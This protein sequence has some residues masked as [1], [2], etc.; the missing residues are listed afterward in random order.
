M[1]PVSVALRV[2]FH[3]ALPMVN[4]PTA[5][6]IEGKPLNVNYFLNLLL[7]FLRVSLSWRGVLH[8]PPLTVEGGVGVVILSLIKEE[9]IMATYVKNKLYMV[10]LAELQPDPTQPRKFMDPLALEELTASVRQNGIIEPIIC[11]QDPKTSLVYV[12]AGE[13]RCAAA[14]QAG[15]THVPAVF[16]M[17]DNYA[18]IALVGNLLRQD[19]N[20]I[21]EA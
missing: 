20:P 9:L 13:R 19:L 21:K 5:A 11:R 4:F 18:E 17:G 15:L 16:I 8:I 1:T 6:I 12:V 2:K 14:R 10:A 3:P 7:R